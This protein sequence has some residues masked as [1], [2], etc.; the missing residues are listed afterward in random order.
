MHTI[1]D[2]RP[3]PAQ[4]TAACA[5][6]SRPPG[7]VVLSLSANQTRWNVTG[8]RLRVRRVPGLSSPGPR[9]DYGWTLRAQA[10]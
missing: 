2:C 3:D 4:L 10:S 8:E 5:R 7:L 9:D 1:A 6:Q